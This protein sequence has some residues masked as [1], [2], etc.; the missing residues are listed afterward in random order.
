MG[1]RLFTLVEALFTRNGF[2]NGPL[3]FGIVSINNG[4]NGSSPMLPII[5]SVTIDIMLNNNGSFFLKKNVVC[6]QAL[7]V[8]NTLKIGQ[9]FKA[10][11]HWLE[12]LR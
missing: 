3:L 2:L 7:S 11:S 1:K 9:T 10:Y 8:V 6:T 5:Q 4:Q 12:V